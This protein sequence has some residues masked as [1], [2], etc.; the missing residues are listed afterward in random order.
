MRSLPNH[1][2][3]LRKVLLLSAFFLAAF[4]YAC[5][6]P[7]DRLGATVQPEEDQ[8]SFTVDTLT[9][10]TSTQKQDSIRSDEL[11]FGM[12]GSAQTAEFGRMKASFYTQLRLSSNNVSF[13]AN[14]ENLQVD[15][16]ILSMEY[17]QFNYGKVIPQHIEVYEIN[18]G[19]D[20]LFTLEENFYTNSR[21][22]VL[23]E[24][25]VE[26]GAMPRSPKYTT[27]PEINGVSLPPQMRVPLK[28]SFAQK[29]LEKSGQP[30][31]SNNTEFLAFFKGLYV[32]VQNPIMGN[33]EGGYMSINYLSSNTL[34]TLYYTNTETDESFS[35][36]F[37]INFDC[38]RFNRYDFDRTASEVEMVLN[39]STQNPE[40][41]YLQVG[42][43][44]FTRVE[45]PN[46]EM[47]KDRSDIIIN[48]AEL[49]FPVE[50][51]FDEN[52][53]P[54]QSFLIAKRLEDG[55]N[56]LIPDQLLG[57]T[58]LDGNFRVNSLEYRIN[59]TR[60]VQQVLTGQSELRPLFI[61]P[62]GSS[63]TANHT[64]LFSANNAEKPAKLRLT[65][66]NF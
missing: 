58:H 8:L 41:L 34:V 9:I 59:I 12:L 65:L 64:V 31:L 63:S 51:D 17:D 37:N 30:E 11:Q 49:I 6:N 19:E 66:T 45:I 28:T 21:L 60:Y 15:S 54:I 35:Y 38:A 23:P 10:L 47:L 62:T 52:F 61:L 16:M 5:E 2:K 18:L 57:L 14:V 46:L 27:R 22:G 43:S 13:G 53:S 3:F 24:N 42:G 48:K 20:T 50:P 39:G 29:F 55:T 36:N 25:L 32:T 7:E 40:K 26:E 4:L 56:D 1:G 44:V 33:N